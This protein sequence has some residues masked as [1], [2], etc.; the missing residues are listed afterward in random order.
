MANIRINDVPQRIQYEA[1]SPTQSA[2]PIPFPF[3]ADTDILVYQSDVLLAQGGAPGQYT[4]TGAGTASGGVMTLVTPA[5][6]GTVITIIGST[7]IDRTSIYSPTISNL[8]GDDLNSDLNRIIIMLQELWTIQNYMQL[9]YKPWLELSQDIDVT[10]DRYLPILPPG[11]TWMKNLDD[12]EIIA[13]PVSGGGGSSTA[14]VI[15]ITQ[16]A[17]GF[18]AGQVVYYNVSQY[19]L[20]YAQNAGEA[21]VIGLVS[22]VVDANNFYLLVAGQAIIEGATFTAGD[23]Y[24]L[25]DTTPG[26]LTLTEPTLPGR[27][28]KPLFIATS[29]EEGFFFNFRGKIIPNTEFQWQAVAVD[30]QMVVNEGYIT[31]GGGDLALTLP[32]SAAVGDTIE[33]KGFASTG[34]HLVQNAGQKIIF[35]TAETSL[36]AGGSLAS[37]ASSDGFKMVCVATNTTFSVEFSIGNITVT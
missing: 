14:I 31:S 17:H 10:V 11:C 6:V 27:I 24:F 16:A 32:S 19:S 25:S 37:T 33:V 23:V 18:S 28:S 3:L 30:T 34:W 8:T 36:G 29:N 9:V 22:N 13:V 26:A 7:P 12:T 15:L 5:V 21:E 2:F 1:S 35:G 20:A 4:L